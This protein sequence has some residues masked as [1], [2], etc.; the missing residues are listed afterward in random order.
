MSAGLSYD[1]E[2]RQEGGTGMIQHE[3]FLTGEK[4]HFFLVFW[5]FWRRTEGNSVPPAAKDVF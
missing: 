4:G 5:S 3:K 2:N 1:P